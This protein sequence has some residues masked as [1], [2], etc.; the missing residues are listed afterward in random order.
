MDI[1]DYDMNDKNDNSGISTG[2]NHKNSSRNSKSKSKQ[3]K[4]LKENILAEKIDSKIF[5][6]NEAFIN[7]CLD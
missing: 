6:Q 3:R 2:N 7:K 4:I 1:N 5:S